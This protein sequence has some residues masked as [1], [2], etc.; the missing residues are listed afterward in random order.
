[1][2]EELAAEGT[3]HD[4]EIEGRGELGDGI[5]RINGL[6]IFV[7]GATQLDKSYRVV[8]TKRLPKCAIAEVHSPL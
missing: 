5:A 3:Y 8:I 2:A 6:V 7:K 4:V 1:M